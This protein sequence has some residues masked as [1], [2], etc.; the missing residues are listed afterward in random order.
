MSESIYN[1]VPVEYMRE[2]KKPMHKSS[3]NP[4]QDV[5]GSTFGMLFHNNLISAILIGF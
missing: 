2:E 5:P 4:K 3:H 1:L